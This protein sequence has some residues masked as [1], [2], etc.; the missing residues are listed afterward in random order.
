M[1]RVIANSFITLTI[2]TVLGV[3]YTFT[4]HE[5]VIKQQYSQYN[6]FIRSQ[7][8]E[9]NINSSKIVLSPKESFNRTGDEAKVLADL[10]TEL[11]SEIKGHK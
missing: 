11:R 6:V 5:T 1:I 2:I 4:W 7:S 10:E 3:L 8:L 9:A